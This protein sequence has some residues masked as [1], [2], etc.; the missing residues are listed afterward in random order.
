LAIASFSSTIV[1]SPSVRPR[2]SWAEPTFQPCFSR[3]LRLVPNRR[4]PF[5]RPYPIAIMK[6]ALKV[7]YVYRR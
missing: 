6:P 2:K 3:V 4:Q 5:D 1:A 7:L